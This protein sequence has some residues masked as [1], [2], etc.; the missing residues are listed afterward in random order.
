MREKTT[1]R[2]QEK[3][4]SK[5]KKFIKTVLGYYEKHGRHE[6]VWRKNITPYKILVSE[7]MLQQT[8][9]SRVIPK[10]TLWIKRYPILSALRK[11]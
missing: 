8:Q 2:K 9:V 1:D 11:T 7:I 5:V 4:T 10:F 3:I 6:L